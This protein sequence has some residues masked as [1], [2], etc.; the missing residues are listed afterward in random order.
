M[1]G[2]LSSVQ[3]DLL[4]GYVSVTPPDV[5]GQAGWALVSILDDVAPA[6]SPLRD[7]FLARYGPGRALTPYD[8]VRRVLEAPLGGADSSAGSA[9]VQLVTPVLRARDTA[10]A[11]ID[12][13]QCAPTGGDQRALDARRQLVLLAASARASGI[14]QDDGTVLAV[15][16]ARQWLTSAPYAAAQPL[17]FAGALGSSAEAPLADRATSLSLLQLDPKDALAG[18]QSCAPALTRD[19]A[20]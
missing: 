8:L 12:A 1:N 6:A 2:Y 19:R 13:E 5:S 14:M 9:L 20:G 10:L 4:T 17:A 15:D 11:L 16:E 18:R 3:D 7:W